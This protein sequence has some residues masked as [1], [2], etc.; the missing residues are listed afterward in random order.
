MLL[1]ALP[2]F[3]AIAAE[4]AR[5]ACKAWREVGETGRRSPGGVL[6][7]APLLLL[8]AIGIAW[9]VRSLELLAGKRAVAGAIATGL[10]AATGTHAEADGTRDGGAPALPIVATDLFWLPTEM[11][12]LWDRI[13]FHLIRGPADL[14]ELS[15]RAAAHGAKGITLV[16]APGSVRGEAPVAKIRDPGYPAFSVDVHV[17]RLERAMASPEDPSR[18]QL[19]R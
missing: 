1:P 16:T 2:V 6:R 5:R 10:T 19:D 8:F 18:A 12:A 15:R 3:A 9:N 4:Q 11:A 17:Q 14:Q 13:E 7:L